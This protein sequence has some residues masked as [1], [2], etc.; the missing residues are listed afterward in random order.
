M[1][2]AVCDEGYLCDVCGKE[3]DAIIDSDLYLRYV[4]GDLSPLELARTRERHIRCH[5]EFAQFI[6]DP[7]F[8]P[9]LC[10]GPFEKSGL[11]G[12]YVQAEEIR[13]TRG[14]RRLQEIPRLGIPITEYPL[15][16]VIEAWQRQR[17]RAP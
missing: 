14:W 13:V 17:S 7:D 12:E 6:V 4:L 5:P 15:P 9:V 8:P 10:T 1:G 16:E 3:V 2:M 11:D